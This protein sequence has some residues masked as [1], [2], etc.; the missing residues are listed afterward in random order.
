MFYN[1]KNTCVGVL[2]PFNNIVGCRIM[3]DKKEASLSSHSVKWVRINTD[4][5][6]ENNLN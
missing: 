3:K 4:L 1:P 5:Q 2:L 6:V